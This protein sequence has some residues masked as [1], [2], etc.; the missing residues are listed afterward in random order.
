MAVAGH[1]DVLHAREGLYLA[2]KLR[3]VHR[4]DEREQHELR[5]V[6]EHN[7]EETDL[8]GAGAHFIGH[9]LVGPREPGDVGDHRGHVA[10]KCSGALRTSP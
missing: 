4:L 2:S 8:H 3:S 9:E 7:R 10:D 1:V 6:G 5:V